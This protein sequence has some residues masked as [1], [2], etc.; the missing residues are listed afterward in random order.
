[1]LPEVTSADY[2]GTRAWDSVKEALPS[3]VAAVKD[4]MGFNV[5]EGDEQVEAYKAAVCAA[6]DVDAS[7]GFS[8]GVAEA[9]ASM[10]LG[11]FS[12][13]QGGGMSSYDRDMD[14]AIRR[15]LS[16]SGLLYQGLG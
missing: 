3:A 1:M 12:I 13:S 4:V 9:G 16:G 5:P 6:M 10:R 14:R 15:A 2:H 8:G 11:T 7:Y